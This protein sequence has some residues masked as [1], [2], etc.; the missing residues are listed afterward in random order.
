MSAENWSF[1]K[2]ISVLQSLAAFGEK[3]RSAQKLENRYG[4]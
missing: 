4:Q 1:Q 3:R 2:R